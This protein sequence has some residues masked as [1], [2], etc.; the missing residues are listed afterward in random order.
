MATG[1]WTY[2]TNGLPIGSVDRGVTSGI[3]P[4][5]GGGS[6]VFGFNSLAVVSGAV[7]LFTNQVNFAPM[8]K[9]GSVRGRT[10]R[11]TGTSSGSKTP[12]PTILPCAKGSFRTASLKRVLAPSASFVGARTPTTLTPGTTCAWT[13]WS[14]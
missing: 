6:F 8:S 10:S 12:S 3:T 1:D 5:N 13:W 9:G 14:T 7:G 11:T 4:P 2:L